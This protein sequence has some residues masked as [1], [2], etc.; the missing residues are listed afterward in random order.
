VEPDSL[1]TAII[2]EARRIEED[3]LHSMKGHFN[4]SSLWGKVHLILG[5]PSAILAGWA[6]VEAFA[7][8]PTLTAIL[9]LS[10]AALT[11]TIT[12]LKPQ[13]VS[14]NHGN[15][16]REYN[17]LKN[18]ARRFREIELPGLGEKDAKQSLNDLADQRDALNSMSP[19]ISRWAYNNAKKDIDEGRS[20]YKV[21]V[22]KK[23]NGAN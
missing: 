16:G 9:A 12:F 20:D 22:E 19:D 2:D 23:N 8:N 13:A 18:K 1:K 5:L 4:A 15:A 7:D 6:G 17:K 10:S 14:D 3:A 11:A 21:D